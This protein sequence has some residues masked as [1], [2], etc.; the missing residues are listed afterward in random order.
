[1]LNVIPQPRI[2]TTNLNRALVGFDTLFKYATNVNAASNYPP[3]NIIRTDDD[4]YVIEIAIAGFKR[5]EISIEV[6]QELL[7]IS[8]SK[9]EQLTNVEYIHR[10]LS[11]RDFTRTFTLAEHVVVNSAT[12]QDGILIVYLERIVPE[13]KKRKVITISEI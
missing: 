12:I 1:M 2:D 10:G 4:H 7:L 3:H 5:S 6:Q 8:G 11:S 9:S 13:E